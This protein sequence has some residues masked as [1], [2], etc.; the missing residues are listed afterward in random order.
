MCAN[1]ASG[2]T[3]RVFACVNLG[4]VGAGTPGTAGRILASGHE[5]DE[6]QTVGAV[7]ALVQLKVGVN[8]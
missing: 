6:L 3:L 1:D 4:E 5:M 8:P 2:F 7:G